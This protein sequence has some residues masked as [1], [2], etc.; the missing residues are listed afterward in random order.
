MAYSLGGCAVHVGR[1]RRVSA[2]TVWR[3]QL[4]TG[5]ADLCFCY[6]SV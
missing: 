3:C 6:F 2:A 4:E 5:W 1:E